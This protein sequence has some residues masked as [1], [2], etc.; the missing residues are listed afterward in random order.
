MK[1]NNKTKVKTEIKKYHFIGIGGMGMGN[2][3]LLMLAKGYSVS[4]SDEKESE[5]TR[6]LRTKGAKIFIGHDLRNIDGVDCVVYSSAITARNPEMFEA[7]RL[8][9]PILKRAELL[10]QLVNKEVG[11]T[12]AGAHGK[13]TTSSMAS[14]LLI[15]AGLKPTTA[16]GG[17]ILQGYNANLGIGRHI[18]AEVD[19]SDGSFL[20]FSPHFSIIT[21]IDRE[22]LDYYKSMDNVLAA[23]AKF[24]ERTVPGGVVI[25]C[26]DNKDLR[27]IVEKGGRRFVTYGFGDDNEWM[28]T[29]IECDANGSSFDCYCGHKLVGRF[30]LAVPGKHNILNSLAVIVLG[31]E[32][33]IEMPVIMETLQTFQGVKRRFERKGEAGGVLVV[34]DYGHHP[35]EIAATLQAARTLGRKRLI[36]VFQPH[37]YSRTQLLMNE[38]AACFTLADHLILMDIY[39]ASEKPIE[40]VTTEALLARI[41]AERPQ[42]LCFMKKEEIVPHLLS[43]VRSGDLVLTLGAGDITNISDTFVGALSGRVGFDHIPS[44]RQ[45]TVD[46]IRALGTI[47]VILGG[48]SSEREVSLRSGGAVVKALTE[49]GCRVKTLDLTTEDRDLIKEWFKSEKIDMAFIALHGRFG[50]DGGLQ[51]ILDEMDI[52]YQGCAPSASYAAFNKVVAQKRFEDHAVRTPRTVAIKGA[53]ALSVEEVLKVA[54]AFPLV[55]KPACE[56]SSIGVALVNDEPALLAAV[57]EA[58]VFGRDIVIQEFIR[59]RELTVGI[60]GNC[61][62]PIVEICV[63]PT[64]EGSA[65]FDS[66]A[67]YEKD[68]TRYIVPAKL[69]A[70]VTSAVQAVALKAYRAL[71]CEGFGR[72]DVLL[73]DNNTPFVLEINT[74]PG[75]TATSLLPKAARAAGLDFQQLCLFLVE[76]AYGKKKA[77]SVSFQH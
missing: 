49:A 18:V 39:P 22:H 73:D 71:N 50:E 58:E 70:G 37:R 45:R 57:R 68:T 23:Y 62:L 15:N 52:P 69:S 24:V 64:G 65:L 48:C 4:G 40:G 76:M 38:F 61:P 30:G 44:A 77:E 26:G 34:D 53:A 2:L 1:R 8:H 25:A 51:V 46:E 7:V 31:F 16:V 56:G 5:L 32:L 27:A 74:I 33:K 10:A 20:Y 66:S 29:N 59:G 28:A 43:V 75:F 41:H 36:V 21:N 9:M 60:L 14:L 12:V 11:I 3:A 6:Q 63:A 17:V 35:T 54:G 47:G 13:T 42:E 55:V 67:K 72:V 19:E